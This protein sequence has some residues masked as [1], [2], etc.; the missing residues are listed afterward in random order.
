MRCNSELNIE[1]N[2]F[3][4]EPPKIYVNPESAANTI[5][6]MDSVTFAIEATGVRPIE[7]Q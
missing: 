4:A 3:T 2:V 7:D 5:P 1:H 6:G